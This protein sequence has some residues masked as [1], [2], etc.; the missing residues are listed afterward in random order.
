R[1][2]FTGGFDWLVPVFGP[3]VVLFRVDN[4]DA[5]ERVPDPADPEG[6]WLDPVVKLPVGDV[7]D[8]FE[9]L[10]DANSGPFKRLPV[11][12]NGGFVYASDTYTSESFRRKVIGEHNGRKILQNTNDTGADFEK[13]AAP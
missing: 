9:A 11:A 13:I 10:M 5:L 6:E 3:T 7:I 8:S 1:V 4:F 2:Y 12:L